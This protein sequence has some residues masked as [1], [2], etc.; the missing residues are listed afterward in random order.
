MKTDEL[1]KM[2]STNLE[3]VRGGELRNVVMTA[4]AGGA[5]VAFCLMLAIFGVP[6]DTLRGEHFV[7]K[8]LALAF[9]LGLVGAGA[10]L[11]VRFARPGDPG[12]KPLIA[13]GLLAS[14][15]TGCLLSIVFPF[16][17]RWRP[18]YIWL[19]P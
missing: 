11:L 15:T 12:R 17:G 9:T 18:H 7:L 10:N 19:P 16:T 5:I 3:P 14:N 4:L 1:I 6:A 2:L 13:I 8:V